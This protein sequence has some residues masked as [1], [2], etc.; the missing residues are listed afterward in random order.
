ME[1]LTLGDLQQI[2]MILLEAGAWGLRWE[3]E[4]TAQS[5]INGGYESVDAYQVAYDDW[6]K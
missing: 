4:T 3:V 6:V 1:E 5:Y 2:E